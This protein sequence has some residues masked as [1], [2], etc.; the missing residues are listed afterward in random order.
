M[1][2]VVALEGVNQ[3]AGVNALSLSISL[4]QIDKNNFKLKTLASNALVCSNLGKL[5]K[6]LVSFFLTIKVETLI[7]TL[8]S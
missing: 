3:R 2:D 7:L 4:S 1:Q 8:R 5:L 6:F